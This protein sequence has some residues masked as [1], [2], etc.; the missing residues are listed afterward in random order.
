[1][2]D[3]SHP[4]QPSTALVIYRPPRVRA[5][6]LGRLARI[7]RTAL[8][9]WGGASLAAVAG[10]TVGA[11]VNGPVSF[12][13]QVQATDKPAKPAPVAAVAPRE[14]AP[15][16][17]QKPKPV[18]ARPLPQRAPAAEIARPVPPAANAEP[19]VAVQQRPEQA[20]VRTTPVVTEVPFATVDANSVEPE[21]LVVARLPRPRP[22]EPRIVGSVD[23]MSPAHYVRRH[24]AKRFAEAPGR[25]YSY[26]FTDRYGTPT[27]IYFAR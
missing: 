5:A 13:A 25:H 27:I 11:A 4:A 17:P 10:M 19:P 24:L 9:V 22:D 1:M 8:M 2:T 20:P 3:I 7:A 15:V 12:T 21:P 23:R 6:I 14:S 16:V 26:R 18:A